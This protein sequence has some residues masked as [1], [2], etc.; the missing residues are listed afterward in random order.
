MIPSV[1][2]IISAYIIFRCVERVLEVANREPIKWAHLAVLVVA[3]LL[4]GGFVISQ[5][6]SVLWY[7][8]SPP[9]PPTTAPPWP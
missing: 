9:D 5:M 3:A 8:T 4:T 2:A 1:A 7:A 6:A